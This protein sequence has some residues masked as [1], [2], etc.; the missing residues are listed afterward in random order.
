MI[1]AVGEKYWPTYFNQINRCLKPGGT[2]V[3]QAIIITGT[4]F[5]EYQKHSDFL[6]HHIFPRWDVAFT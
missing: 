4:K 3:I 6:R 1:E 5:S 2:A